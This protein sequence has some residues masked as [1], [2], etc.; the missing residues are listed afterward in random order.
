[1]I[2]PELGHLKLNQV[3]ANSIFLQ[4]SISTEAGRAE[5]MLMMMPKLSLSGWQLMLAQLLHVQ[6]TSE[7]MIKE[8]F[9]EG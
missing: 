7:R 9:A 2:H 4:Q 3:K 6:E 1:M 8:R 5:L